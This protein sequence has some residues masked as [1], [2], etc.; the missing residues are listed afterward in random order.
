[1]KKI[2][3]ILA[4]VQITVACNNSQIT[5]TTTGDSFSIPNPKKAGQIA[6]LNT[7]PVCG[8]EKDSTWEDYSLNNHDTV[9]FCSPTCKQA[10]EGNRKKYLGKK[11]TK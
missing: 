3:L 2:F 10:F 11:T 1:M 6:V 5:K 9:W 7:D 4:I 8:M